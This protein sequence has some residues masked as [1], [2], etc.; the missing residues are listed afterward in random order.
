VPGADAWMLSG[1]GAAVAAGTGV[2][3]ASP[4]GAGCLR[5]RPR[6]GPGRRVIGFKLGSMRR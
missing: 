2:V 4:L 3:A 1:A 6:P 5:G